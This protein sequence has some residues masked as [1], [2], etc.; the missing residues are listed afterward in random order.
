VS[1]NDFN[2]GK[3]HNLEFINILTDDGLMNSNT[4]PFEGQ[5]RFDARYTVVEALKAKGLYDHWEDNAMKIP[6]C[7]KTKDVIEPLLKPVNTCPT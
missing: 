3:S 6:L 4:G 2:L 7:S 5:K 1:K